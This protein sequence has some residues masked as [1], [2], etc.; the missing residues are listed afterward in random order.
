MDTLADR[1]II[2]VIM[3]LMH[4]VF[5]LLGICKA[6][7]KTPAI[8]VFG[9]SLVDAGNN[10]YLFTIAKANVKPNG[11]DFGRPTGRFTNG[12]T[13]VDII[14][15]FF[16][17]FFDFGP[18]GRFTNGRTIPPSF[19]LSFFDVTFIR[20]F[21][22]TGQELG[23]KDFIPPYLDPTTVGEAVLQ[24]VNYA[25]STG[26]IL[27]QTGF[28]FFGRINMDE[29]ID[30]FVKTR[31]DIISM[32][33]A[34]AAQNLL[35][36]ALFTITIG[37]ND[38]MNKYTL[39]IG[40]ISE[41]IVASTET[42]VAIL[43]SKYRLQVTRLYDLDARKFLV[44]S[45][46]PIG[47]IPFM[48][49]TNSFAGS[50]NCVGKSNQVVQLF[51]TRLKSLVVELTANLEGSKFVYADGYHILDDMIRNYKEY[52]FE[53][54]DSACCRLVGRHGGLFPCNPISKL[55]PDRSK[56]LFWDLFHPSDAAN[57]IITK[58]LMYGNDSRD[59]WPMNIRQLV[60]S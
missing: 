54:A 17:P 39:P 50:D 16:L 1:K 36:K 57:L 9:D 22:T 58:R 28:F 45:I 24:G 53:N 47:C 42:I 59:V 38:F 44:T 60:E 20:G 52:G 23:L 11:I 30:Y 5:A 33:G 56:Y 41:R 49:D 8:F 15:S 14:V 40:S 32:I 55:C 37:S 18:T 19:F 29:Q 13:I 12:R 43:I 48:R 35:N 27:K 10:N 2:A 7:N 46:A 21:V 26:G 4:I 51:N 3:S 34:P 31:Q 6:D 25:S